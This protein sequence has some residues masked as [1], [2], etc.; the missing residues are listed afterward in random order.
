MRGVA[1]ATAVRAAGKPVQA[2]G[3]PAHQGHW[4]W[5]GLPG[6]TFRKTQ[7]WRSVPEVQSTE[8]ITKMASSRG[9]VASL[10]NHYTGAQ[11]GGRTDSKSQGPRMKQKEHDSKHR[12]EHR[13][14]VAQRRQQR[15]SN[16][17]EENKYKSD[18]RQ[19]REET[20]ANRRKRIGQMRNQ[21][22]TDAKERVEL[23]NQQRVTKLK[24]RQNLS[25][26]QRQERQQEASRVTEHMRDALA[27]H[28][29]YRA[30][31]Y[32]EMKEQKKNANADVEQRRKRLIQL[33]QARRREPTT[34]NPSPSPRIRRPPVPTWVVEGQKPESP[35]PP[36]SND[37][38]AGTSTGVAARTFTVK[39][40]IGVV[41]THSGP[42]PSPRGVDGFS[43]ELGLGEKETSKRATA[44][45]YENIQY[46]KE[47]RKQH[48]KLVEERKANR[49]KI[50]LQRRGWATEDAS[51]NADVVVKRHQAKCDIVADRR[52]FKAEREALKAKRHTQQSEF[53]KARRQAAAREQKQFEEVEE[54][55]RVA[56][57]TAKAKR[58]QENKQFQK[59]AHEGW[60]QI[61][62]ASQ[63][64]NAKIVTARKQNGKV[65]RALSHNLFSRAA[66]INGSRSNYG[67]SQPARVRRSS[68]NIRSEVMS[69]RNLPDY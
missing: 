15:V 6:K 61:M 64:R 37:P 14:E 26:D 31:Q 41:G 13:Q 17:A 34:N 47:H 20:I 55:K 19:N 56:V 36:P 11:F 44:F 30:T 68:L 7:M 46:G 28:K 65:H 4:N 69:V 59:A 63:A 53:Q 18:I 24:E 32:Q 38:P 49:R 9:G 1:A 5:N 51:R 12:A 8:A 2:A 60:T 66:V 52:G 45:E 22:Y 57:M 50:M 40:A 58:Y 16:V 10:L 3:K 67:R 42:P 35:K 29:A 62:A 54:A 33:V 43:L 39:N 23:A 48:F 25:Q 21:R 27:R